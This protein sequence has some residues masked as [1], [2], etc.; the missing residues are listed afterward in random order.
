MFHE[1]GIYY[2]TLSYVNKILSRKQKLVYLDVFIFH[3]IT[4]SSFIS[5]FL[6][7]PYLF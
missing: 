5:Y 3:L 6:N 7:F 2:S 4:S 1:N